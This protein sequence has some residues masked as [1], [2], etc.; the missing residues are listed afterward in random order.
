MAKRSIIAA[1][2]KGRKPAVDLKMNI[3]TDEMEELREAANGDEF[4]G[5]VDPFHAGISIGYN[6]AKKEAKMS[7][8]TDVENWIRSLERA[9]IEELMVRLGDLAAGLPFD[10]ECMDI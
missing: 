8:K 1:V 4:K 7:F 9:D 10:L 2:E 6:K 3:G 5:I